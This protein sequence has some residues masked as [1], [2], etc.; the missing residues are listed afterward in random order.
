M[1]VLQAQLTSSVQHLKAAVDVMETQMRQR[2]LLESVGQMEVEQLRHET[3]DLA[4]IS[5]ERTK[6]RKMPSHLLLSVVIATDGEC[7]YRSFV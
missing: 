7:L 3:Q 4:A 6:I 1:L 2:Q 5:D